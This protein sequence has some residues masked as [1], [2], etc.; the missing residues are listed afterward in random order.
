MPKPLCKRSHTQ[1][2]SSRT[3]FLCTAAAAFAYS[4]LHPLVR[5]QYLPPL[6]MRTPPR[7]LDLAKRQSQNGSAP[8]VVVNNCT[9]QIC[10][11]IN[12]QA[13][14]GP[15]TTGFCLDPGA[16]KTLSV[17]KDWQGRVWGRTN[18]SFPNNGAPNPACM[19]GD[20][21]G[22]EQCTLAVSN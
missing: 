5:A 11:G 2:F 1:A 17:S 12:S 4:S 13:G 10:P 14:T 8:M 15:Y 9:E 20:C 19:T 3:A 6:H 7:P 22:A 16:N 18:C 21:G